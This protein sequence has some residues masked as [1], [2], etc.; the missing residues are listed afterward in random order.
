MCRIEIQQRISKLCKVAP[1]K[2]PRT[3]VNYPLSSFGILLILLRARGTCDAEM[4]EV[5]A[6]MNNYTV[7]ARG[8]FDRSDEADNHGRC[9]ALWS[10][11]GSICRHAS[12]LILVASRTIDI[13]T[14]QGK[15]K[16]DKAQYISKP[17]AKMLGTFCGRHCPVSFS[18][19][20][21]AVSWKQAAKRL[22]PTFLVPKLLVTDVYF[23]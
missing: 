13:K 20:L 17:L 23:E 18:A 2:T 12:R 14:M 1:H 9:Q 6:L 21:L 3:Q 4:G 10:D 11:Q 16:A 5:A 22:N 15:Q 8:T 19:F 7:L